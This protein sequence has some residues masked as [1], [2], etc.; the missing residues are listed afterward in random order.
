MSIPIYSQREYKNEIFK[1]G[2]N[3][4]DEFIE[5]LS[6]PNDSN[7]KSDIYELI[8]WTEDK[9]KSLD[10]EINRLDTETIPLLLASKHINDNYKTVLIYMH[11]DGQPVDLTK[12]DQENPFI[13]VYKLKENGKFIEYDSN[14]I[15]DIDYKTLQE[16]DIRI[17]A[18]ASS[19]A[20]GPVMMLIQA[21]KFM[22]TNNIDQKLNLKLVMD[23]EEEI[24][25]P[26]LPDAVKKHST[27]L[28]SDAL[29]IFDGPQHESDLPTL[30]FGNRGIS[31]ITLKTYGPVLPQ[32][33]GHFGNYAPNP[34]FRMSNILSSMKDENGIVKIEGY[35]DG[36]T[37]SDEIKKYL[38]N[39]P[40]NEESM[41]DK[42]QFK[43]PE[44]VGN[45]YQEAIQ[46]PSLNVRGI[47]AG[48]VEDEVRTIVPS[49]SIAEIDVRLAIESD[50]YRL[51]ELIKKHIED[52]G[53]VI[54]DH[55]PSKE[56]RMEYDKIVKFNSTVSYPAFRTDIDSDLGNWLSKTLT[57]TFGVEPVLRRTSGGSVPISPFVNVLNIPAVGVPTVNKDNNQHS[58]NEN[59]KLINYI[60]GIESFVGI[61]SSEFK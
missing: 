8:D 49:E 15:K 52:L 46:F 34:V 6:Y 55:E 48:W 24:S 45:S 54:L 18:R 40:D 28:K 44:S 7:F 17:F 25:S 10:F 30:N 26:S 13:P 36:I 33:S 57:K 21:L 47:K 51:H 50:G 39:V 11:L 53:Y 16:K 2:L 43:K 20:K 4:I 29:L 38:D 22:N 60:K 32:H 5:F 31:S 56:E 42:M 58:P 41:L 14:E 1:Q 19:D 37:I 35:Y 9:F 12:W 27:I 61:L 23:F 3:N 59:I